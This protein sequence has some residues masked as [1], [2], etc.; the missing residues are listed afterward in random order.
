MPARTE[1][2]SAF[3][4]AALRTILIVFLSLTVYW[5]SMH[6]EFLW[7]DAARISCR[8]RPAARRRS[9]SAVARIAATEI[10]RSIRRSTAFYRPP[11]RCGLGSVDC[12]TEEYAITRILHG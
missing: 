1:R 6:G 5:P 4:S 2:S 12:R 3:D 11:A 8:E 9:D 7:D 10:C